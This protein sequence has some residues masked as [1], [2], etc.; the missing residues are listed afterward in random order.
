METVIHILIGVGIFF[1]GILGRL[2]L[3]LLVLTVLAIPAL[4]A[5][6]WNRGVEALWQKVRGASSFNGLP[7]RAGLYYAPAHTWL[8]RR[9]A[10]VRIGLDSIAQRI[11]LG[12]E[13]V[14]LPAPGRKMQQGEVAGCIVCGDKSAFIASPVDGVVT[15]VNEALYRDPSIL[16]GDSYKEGWLFEVAP[17]S[18]SY[19]HLRYGRSARR[20]F[21]AESTRMRQFLERDLGVAAADGGELV[22]GTP[23]ML[24]YELWSAL[25]EGFLAPSAVNPETISIRKKKAA[26]TDQ[27]S[28]GITLV[29]G[30][31][32]A[33]AGGLYILVLPF[34]MYGALIWSVSQRLT[35]RS[36]TARLSM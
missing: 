20:W 32:G 10:G 29:R 18:L 7:W 15:A 6:N 14:Q 25:T 16:H 23:T 35:H 3:G 4:I 9:G 13:D 5:G 36:G 8:K 33:V 27:P 17:A 2:L 21:G 22:L 26:R 12:A 28:W 31:G 24:T 19:Q 30:V 11:V 1:A 34:I